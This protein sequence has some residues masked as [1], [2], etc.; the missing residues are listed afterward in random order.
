LAEQL[1]KDDALGVALNEVRRGKAL[2]VAVARAKVSTKDGSLVDL[3]EFIGV[4]N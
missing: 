2:S 3:S 4:A 1:V